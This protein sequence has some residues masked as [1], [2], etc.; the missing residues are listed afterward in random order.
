[1]LQSRLAGRPTRANFRTGTLTVATL[2][3]MRS[4][5][6]R[7]ICLVGLDDGVFPRTGAV[8]GDDVLARRPLTGERD[9][10]SEDRQLLLD[11]V[12]AAT[13]RLVITYSGADEQSGA[14]R[15]PAV[16]LGEILD[17]AD[18][19]TATPVREVIETRH[20]LQPHDARNFDPEQPFS[21]DSASLA[22]ARSA[23]S[24]RREPPP[25]LRDP[26]PTRPRG[27]VSLQD[28]KAFVVHPV[29]AFLRE[30]LDVATP[31]EPDDLA[32][33]IPVTLDNLEKWQIGDRLLR[34]VLAGQD[35]VAVMTAEQL[36]GTLPPGGLGEV[37]LREVVDEC[38]RL[39]ARTD[40]VRQGER[41]SVDVDVDLGDGRRLTGTVPG[42]HGTRVVSLGYSRLKP[43]QRLQ[44]WIDLVALAA[45]YPDQHWTGHAIGRERAGPKRALTGPLDHRAVGWLRDL[46][47]LRDEG[48]C[49]PLPVPV[50]TGA[51]WAEAHVRELMGQD[52]PPREAARR[53]WETDPHH[54]FGITG[55]DADAYHQRVYGVG[56]PVE[57]L[58]EAG[59]GELAWRIWEPLLTGAERIGPL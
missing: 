24:V 39:W 8:D 46:V 40:E 20:P 49:R 6:H 12:L 54:A 10:R 30:R 5:P 7:V 18:R 14:R 55:E 2:V 29:R 31:F 11:A 58:I 26:L 21:F 45:T 35:P 53:E 19:T 34:E 4:V 36:S 48:L 15:P 25:L 50:A 32:D 33:A 57:A 51:A 17:A 59:L 47:D 27:D 56:A 13:E 22:G 37:A 16:P 3:P 44:T 9:A 43:R 42:V 41:R 23:W 1:M 38:Q 52:T 28:L